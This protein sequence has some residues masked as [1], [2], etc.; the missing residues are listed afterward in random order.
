SPDPARPVFRSSTELMLLA[1]SLRVNP[2]GQPHIPGNLEV[3]R[4]LFIHHPHGKYDGRLTR[5]AASWKN[6]DDVIEALFGLS[7]KS[8][9]NEPLKIFLALN[10]VDRGRTKPM[11]AELASRLVAGYRSFGAQYTLFADAPALSEGSIEQYLDLCRQS[12]DMR[13]T[14]LRADDIGTLQALGDCGEFWSC[15]IPSRR[16]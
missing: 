11:S 6:D 14:L 4:N 8:V 9:E 16:L 12:K 7:R 15:R 2:D 1:T 3:W 10:D 13:D 5:S